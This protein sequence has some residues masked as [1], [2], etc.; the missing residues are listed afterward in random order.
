MAVPFPALKQAVLDADRDPSVDTG[1]A[2]VSLL[3]QWLA[4]HG[5]EMGAR[6]VPEPTDFNGTMM[7]WFHWYGDDDGQ[8]W[9]RLKDAAPEL[10]KIGITGLWLPP[11]TKACCSSD[12]G[13]GLDLFDLGEFHQQHTVAT[14]HGTRAEYEAAIAACHAV[15]IQVYADAVLN[16]KTGA[17]DTAEWRCPGG[18]VSVWV[19]EAALPEM[20]VI[21]I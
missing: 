4:T 3:R 11:A 7:Q 10:A 16:H 12:V 8:H 13:Y 18:S 5:A 21:A 15:G 1:Q 6:A 19:E 9:R 17:A 14:K 20:G 2:S